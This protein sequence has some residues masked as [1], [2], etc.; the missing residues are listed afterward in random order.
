M[1]H[2]EDPE[3]FKNRIKS[4][5][6]GRALEPSEPKNNRGLNSLPDID[7]ASPA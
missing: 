2:L 6:N 5:N 1:G 3:F 4:D 7:F